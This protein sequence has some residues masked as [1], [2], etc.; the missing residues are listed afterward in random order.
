MYDN[1]FDVIDSEEKAYWLGFIYADGYIASITNAK[2]K[3]FRIEVSL[4]EN[5]KNHLEK[6]STFLGIS[7]E[8]KIY[9]TN[10][11]RKNRAR[12]FFNNKIIWNKLNNLGCKPNKSLTLEFPNINIF[13]N[14]YLIKHF[15][16][17]YVDGDG[18]I[19]IGKDYNSLKIT[20]TYNFLNNI[21]LNLP[22]ENI[23][24]IWKKKN[25]NVFDLTFNN[26]RGL[27]IL[28]YL[29]KDATIFLDRKY[30]KYKEY[31]RLYEES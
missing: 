8:V 11:P 14:I 6:L 13:S 12:L 21:Q 19:Y 1:I 9:K 29:Y 31:C 24:K 25:A 23:N 18:C 30:I 7:K 26:K 28:N 5:D 15:I 22:L 10:Y 3:S 20:G 17:G 27:Y 2:K 4:N 16:R